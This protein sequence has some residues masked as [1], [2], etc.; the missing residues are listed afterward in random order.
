MLLQK[1]NYFINLQIEMTLWKERTPLSYILLYPQVL[2]IRMHSVIQSS[3]LNLLA[4]MLCFGIFGIQLN[5]N[6]KLHCE[7]LKEYKRNQ[8]AKINEHTHTKR[9]P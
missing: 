1:E 8:I 9:L 2:K 7:K 3:G 4:A 5:L 6:W